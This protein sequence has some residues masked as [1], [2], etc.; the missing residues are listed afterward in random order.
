MLVPV[1]A[2][3]PTARQQEVAVVAVKGELTELHR[4]ADHS[5]IRSKTKVL[6]TWD[7]EKWPEMCITI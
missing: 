7:F 3:I 5:D 1:L 2:Q 4:L 6:R